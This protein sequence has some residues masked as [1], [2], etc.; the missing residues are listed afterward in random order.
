M[1][2]YPEETPLTAPEAAEE[3]RAAEEETAAESA[4]EETAKAETAKAE[5]AEEETA[6]AETAI[7]KRKTWLTD[8]KVLALTW[9]AFALTCAFWIAAA[10]LP[11]GFDLFRPETWALEGHLARKL[12]IYPDEVIYWR[13]SRA[14]GL[15]TGL[16]VYETPVYYSKLGYSLLLSPLFMIR[17]G[18]ARLLCAAFVNVLVMCSSVFPARRLARRITSSRPAQLACVLVTAASPF[19]ALTLTFMTE[20]LFMPLMMWLILAYFALMDAAEK[21]AGKACG[22]LIAGAALTGVLAFGTYLVKDGGIA[23][24]AAF[25]VFMTARLIRAGKGKRWPFAIAMLAHAAALLVCWALKGALLTTVNSYAHQTSLANLRTLYRAEYFLFAIL[26]MAPFYLVSLMILPVLWPLAV[27]RRGLSPANRRRF[28]FLLLTVFFLLTA[29]SFSISVREDLGKEIPRIHTRYLVGLLPVFCALML[30]AMR[31][32]LRKWERRRLLWVALGSTLLFVFLGPLTGG[33]RVD[34]PDLKY[35]QEL[36]TLLPETMKGKEI[37][38]IAQGPLILALVWLTV[39]MAP[40]LLLARFGQ[41]RSVAALTVLAV[42]CAGCCSSALLIGNYRDGFATA[43]EKA[44]D[45]ADLDDWLRGE[46]EE[47]NVL[48]IRESY[49]S[50]AGTVPDAYFTAPFHET[51]FEDLAKQ[52]GTDGTVDL[53]RTALKSGMTRY[54]DDV[55]ASYPEGTGFRYVIVGGTAKIDP[56]CAEQV[57]VYKALNFTVWRLNDPMTLKVTK[58][59]DKY[60]K[61]QKK[62]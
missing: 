56:S 7:P 13:L 62:D 5:P 32:P 45:A 9:I 19:Y 24:T 18:E 33:T 11:K 34:H 22:R 17:D 46:A 23:L 54:R 39:F 48:Y 14:I 15:G 27:S 60:P 2:N 49:N 57:A 52:V 30:E 61:E 1:E 28:G 50:S 51:L 55:Y 3:P 43:P 37:E 58:L 4:E 12:L 47:G 31:C 53:S 20:N 44:R 42:L 21:P 29:V 38:T 35:Y 8:R 16:A 26:R 40:I 25:F 41:K 36:S 10:V 59:G 6:K